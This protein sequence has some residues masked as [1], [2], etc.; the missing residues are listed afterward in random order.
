MVSTLMGLASEM[1]RIGDYAEGIAAIVLRG[2]E[3]LPGNVPPSFGEMAQR[4]RDMLGIATRA[5]TERDAGAVARLEQADDEVDR[6][7]RD[8]VQEL[9]KIMRD[10]PQRSE[11]ATYLVWATH[12]LERIADR[13]V[14][15]AERASFVATG[16][17]VPTRS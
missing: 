15:I 9:L 6:M 4:A 1:E 17:L 3:L 12:N 5:I 14:N 16:I 13:T 10:Q 2:A 11:A 8:T 7:Y